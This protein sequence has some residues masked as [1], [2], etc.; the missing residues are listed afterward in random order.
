M[1]MTFIKIN[2]NEFSTL[3]NY[4]IITKINNEPTNLLI[5]LNNVRLPFNVQKY[6]GNL[7]INVEMF[8]KD[9]QYDE[10]IKKITSLEK[11]ITD[12]YETSL[13]FISS[14]KKRSNEHVHIKT[15]CK[16]I[17]KNLIITANDD[18]DLHELKNN[19]LENDYK[20]SVEI[21]PDFLW[22][23]NDTFGINF[24]I[25]SIVKI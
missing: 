20:Y 8:L 11:Y 17:K 15:M 23:N 24:I 2:E 9:E 19:H 13:N 22:Q 5:K 16:R 14:I 18:I 21:K 25:C 10:N 7:Y 12:K 6:N 4:K 1:E 3:T